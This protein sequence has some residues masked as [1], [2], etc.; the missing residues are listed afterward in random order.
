MH[1]VAMEHFSSPNNV[2]GPI[3]LDL[4]SSNAN[5]LIVLMTIGGGTSPQSVTGVADSNGNSWSTTGAANISGISSSVTSCWYVAN[6][7]FSPSATLT[8]NTNGNGDTGGILYIISG[9]A[10]SPFGTRVTDITA[11]SSPGNLSVVN[12]TPGNTSGIVLGTLGVNFNT[13][14]GIASPSGAIF[15][16]DSYGGENISGPISVDENNGWGH[17]YNSSDSSL[18]WTWSFWS[19]SL[20]TG[21]IGGEADSFSAGSAAATVQP[22]TNLKVTVQ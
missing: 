5:N 7:N 13:V 16:S 10:A 11:Q 8:I 2:T 1:I 4:P 12:I 21:E 6:N 14:G 18:N 17:L 9:A 20:A 22:P 19:S 15:D 3:D